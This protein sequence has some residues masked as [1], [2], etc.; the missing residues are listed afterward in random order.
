VTVNLEIGE[1]L[2]E[3]RTRLLAEGIP[4]EQISL[5][6]HAVDRDRATH[7]VQEAKNNKIGSIV[8]GRRGLITFIDEY[9]IGRISDQVLKLAD[10][11][12]VWVI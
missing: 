6:I 3:A 10:E 9:F 4:T 12:A 5:R 1:Q 11:L 7:I 2:E 8:V